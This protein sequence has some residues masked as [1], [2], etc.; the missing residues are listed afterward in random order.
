MCSSPDSRLQ[1]NPETPSPSFPQPALISLGKRRGSA[2]QVGTGAGA[3]SSAEQELEIPQRRRR[4]QGCAGAA[5]AQG[6]SAGRAVL[7]SLTHCGTGAAAAAAPAPS[8]TGSTQ[9]S[10]HDFSIALS[11]FSPPRHWQST[12]HKCQ[13]KWNW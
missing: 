6:D 9:L 12:D 13:D 2:V 1:R 4:A 10:S 7:G 8:A 11:H 5:H 3:S